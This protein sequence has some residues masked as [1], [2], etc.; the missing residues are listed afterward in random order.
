M[1]P[2][3]R[4]CSSVAYAQYA[5][6]SRLVRR[7]PRRSRCDTGFHHGLLEGG[8]GPL[9]GAGV[10]GRGGVGGRLA[11]FRPG[12]LQFRCGDVDLCAPPEDR[13]ADL[14]PRSRPGSSQSAMRTGRGEAQASVV[15]TLRRQGSIR[16]GRRERARFGSGGGLEGVL[17]RS[18]HSTRRADGA[19]VGDTGRVVV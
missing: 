9:S 19:P 3:W 18:A 13:G 14:C 7:A 10:P 5:P 8:R 15:R 16:S 11:A 1:H 4:R 6:S 2:A 17:R 12:T